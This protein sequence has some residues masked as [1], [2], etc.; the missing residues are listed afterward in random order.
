M[1]FDIAIVGGGTVG[2]A[3]ASVLPA[4]GLR[5]ALIEPRTARPLPATGFDR[6]VYALNGRSRRICEE[7]GIWPH[8]ERARVAPVHRMRVFGDDASEIDFSAY[9]SSVAELA[10]LVEESNLQ[11]A[12]R[13][14]LEGRE[15]LHRIASE[16]TGAIWADEAVRLS[17]SAG[18]EVTARLVVAADGADSALRSAAGIPARVQ[19]YGQAGVVA[20]F[21]AE[22]HH[23]NTAFQWFSDEGVLALLPM[24]GGEVSMVWSAPDALAR[25]LASMPAAMLSA[26]VG[27]R[28]HGMLGRLEQ[29]GVTATFPLRRMHVTR[30]VGPRLALVG[31]TAHNVHPLAGQ[32]LNL[33]L[34]DVQVLAEILAMR[35]MEPDCGAPLLL[36]RYERRRREDLLAMEAVTDGMQALFASTAPGVRRLRNAGLRLANRFSPLKRLLVKQ[37]VG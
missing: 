24:A 1:D 16:C 15:G 3:L 25:E 18:G 11:Q 19:D 10:V 5:V 30:L 29:T 33:G 26:R 14:A 9:S 4:D 7:A 28:S 37:A 8:L 12:L 35:G 27:A 31:D 20:N 34:A 6:R 23:G 2:A 13:A 32:G 17:L 21:R 36:R 22:K